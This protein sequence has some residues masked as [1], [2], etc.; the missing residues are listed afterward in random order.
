M[1]HWKTKQDFIYEQQDHPES[2][3]GIIQTQ[4]LEVLVDIRDILKELNDHI[5][6]F[7]NQ[8]RAESERI[9]AR[10]PF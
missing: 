5:A 3:N 7:E 9:R 10:G 4:I 2:T 6:F 8:K 1:E